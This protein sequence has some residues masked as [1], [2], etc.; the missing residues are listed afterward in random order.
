MIFNH[1]YIIYLA[2]NVVTEGKLGAKKDP[3]GPNEVVTSESTDFHMGE[4]L[5]QLR[6]LIESKS[7]QERPS[8]MGKI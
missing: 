7:F 6:K 1:I 5:D 4:L 2:E 3:A 8:S